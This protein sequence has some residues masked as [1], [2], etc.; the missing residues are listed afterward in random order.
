MSGNYRGAC[1][2]IGQRLRHTLL[3]SHW[4]SCLRYWQ[5]FVVVI[6]AFFLFCLFLFC[7]FNSQALFSV[8]R[9]IT[10][11]L[12]LSLFQLVSDTH[13]PGLHGDGDCDSAQCSYRTVELHV[14]W[15]QNQRKT[16]VCYRSNANCYAPGAQQICQIRKYSWIVIN[17][18]LAFGCFFSFHIIFVWTFAHVFSRLFVNLTL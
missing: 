1:A 13:S 6:V 17:F 18:E 5:K 14:Q 9:S 8:T 3:W 2:L 11:I 15:S 7:V 16:A 12:F 4:V 10:C